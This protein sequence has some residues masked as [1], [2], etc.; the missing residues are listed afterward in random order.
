M[1]YLEKVE[2]GL[3]CQQQNWLLD[4]TTFKFL[5]LQHSNVD[6][7][8]QWIVVISFLEQVISSGPRCWVEASKQYQRELNTA[9]HPHDSE[10]H[11]EDKDLPFDPTFGESLPHNAQNHLLFVGQNWRLEDTWRWECCLYQYRIL[12][13][14]I[15]KSDMNLHKQKTS[16]TSS[17]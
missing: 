4:G 9:S 11:Q 16:P 14:W 13:C 12:R 2:E 6:H 7:S 17:L 3:C 10:H 8:K 1:A 5:I 15:S